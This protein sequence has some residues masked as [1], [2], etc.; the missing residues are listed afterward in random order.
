MRPS[1]NVRLAMGG[2][3]G[4]PFRSFLTTLGVIIGVSA[5][6]I[7]VSIGTGAK[8]QTES[9]IQ[10][11]GSNLI[12]VSSGYRSAYSKI[13]NRILPA[14]EQCGSVRQA[15]PQINRSGTASYGSN[16]LSTTAIG[17]SANYLEVRNLKMARGVFLSDADIDASTWN[18]VLGADLATEL[19][20][21]EDPLGK[22]VRFDRVRFTV[23]GV[24]ASQGDTGFSSVDNVMFIPYTT[25]QKR[26][27]GNKNISTISVQAASDKEM[28]TA[29]D[30]VYA[31]LLLETG[32]ERAFRLS[33]QAD[34]LDLAAGMT[35]TM[36]LLLSGIAAVSLLVGGIGIM[37][38]M[39]VSVTERI[40]EIGIRKAIG[41][42][43]RQ[44]LAQFIM[45][46]A[47][48][49]VS[50]GLLGIAFGFLGSR[51]V[52]RVFNWP[53]AVD[54]RSV[55]LGFSLSLAVGVFFGAYPAYKA[56]GLD[57]IEGLRHE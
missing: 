27:T 51:I 52:T 30:Q 10:R 1:D 33:S 55:I 16:A 25:M 54:T 34:V 46:A 32:D 28:D 39:L 38:I 49:S 43:E 11:L 3:M 41:A 35:D 12:T 37:N 22:R 15:T 20:E 48:L 40:R 14:I 19:F 18:C 29:Y 36:T 53:T 17:T 2:L 24:A 47:T 4:S 44:M 23:V 31:T 21:E 42:K 57:P 26:L 5:V 9:Q 45:E 56:A 50:G 6:I 8:R 7:T 13:T